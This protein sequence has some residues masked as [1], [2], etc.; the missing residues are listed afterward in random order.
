MIILI[1]II[2]TIKDLKVSTIDDDENN[3]MLK[4]R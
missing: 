3:V 1:Y 2:I 4:R